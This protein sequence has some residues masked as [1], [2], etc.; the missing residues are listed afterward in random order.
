[1]RRISGAQSP[2]AATRLDLRPLELFLGEI[3]TDFDAPNRQGDPVLAVG[4]LPNTLS[5]ILKN[6]WRDADYREKIVIL[7]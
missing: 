3:A 7:T 4:R 2:G 6:G 5:I 1:L